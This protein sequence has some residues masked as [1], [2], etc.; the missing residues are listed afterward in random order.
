M[1]M[2]RLG[3]LSLLSILGV[4]L[5][6]SCMHN[7]VTFDEM[8]WRKQVESQSIEMLYAP[9]FEAGRYFN[10]WMPMEQGG[11]WRF[12]RWRLSRKALYSEEDKNFSPGFIPEL[13]KRIRAMPERDFIAWIGHGT[14]LLRIQ[15]EYWLTDPMFS[16]RALLPKRITPPAITGDALRDLTPRLNVLISHNHYDHLDEDS[17]RSLPRDSRIYVPLGLKKDLESF[18]NGPVQELDWWQEIDLGGGKKLV[19]LPAQHWSR[20]IGQGYNQTLWA[21]YLLMTPE[22]SVYYGGDSGYFIG[23]G[24]IGRRFPQI[25]YALLAI[26]AYH[27]RW[28]M[29][30]A[31]MNIA[32]ALEAFRDLGAK[33]FIP[34]QWG[35]FPL[36]DE[37]PGFPALDLMRTIQD[38]NLD[39]S[40]FIFLDI[41]EIL[42]LRQT[43]S[44]KPTARQM[45]VT[46]LAY[47]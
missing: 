28:F 39:P 17:I 18:H 11:P 6:L 35:A 9:H 40:R 38:G 2:K 42:P 22:T 43:S 10:P 15:G 41:G 33:H 30:Y 34:N 32:E 27:P 47:T 5:F 4:L 46:A 7:P 8:E 14:F 23:Y 31:H 45:H 25:D 16:E 29:H 3:I 24:E 1:T 36:G 13:S 20:R 44:A 12:L 37:P 26:T 19:C 21:S